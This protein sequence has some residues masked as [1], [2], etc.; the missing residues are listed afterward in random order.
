MI[1]KLLEDVSLYH[2]LSHTQTV[3]NTLNGAVFY[4]R[5]S[6]VTRKT[7]G[8]SLKLRSLEGGPEQHLPMVFLSIPFDYL[9]LMKVYSYVHT[10]ISC[11]WLSRKFVIQKAYLSFKDSAQWVALFSCKKECISI[12]TGLR[13]KDEQALASESSCH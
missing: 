8:S 2:R 5:G 11:L 3:A 4:W 12:I 1:T 13:P 7:S 6:L 10:V 9:P